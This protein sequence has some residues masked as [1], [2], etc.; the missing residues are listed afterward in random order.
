M[1]INC[2][3]N[4]NLPVSNNI[5]FRGDIAIISNITH[6]HNRKLIKSFIKKFDYFKEII[7][8]PGDI[9]VLFDTEFFISDV[10]K[11]T[12]NHR[13]IL[14]NKIDIINDNELD[15]VILRDDYYE[16]DGIEDTIKIYGQSYSEHKK[17]II[18]SEVYKTNGMSHLKHT[19]DIINLRN[20]IPKCDI[21]ITSAQPFGNKNVVCNLL[22]NKTLDIKP[23]YHIYNGSSTFSDKQIRKYNDIT[24]INSNIY[25]NNKQSYIFKY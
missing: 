18:N 17:Y 19:N 21:L 12:F 5:D 4:I 14:R 16:I 23:K 25:I 15:I 11:H 7:F 22:F 3:S 1:I 13:K 20:K 10:Y 9:D 8:I 24:F 2:M 6:T